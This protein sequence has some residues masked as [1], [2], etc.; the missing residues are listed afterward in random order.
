MFE[1][2]GSRVG[3]LPLG[4]AGSPVPTYDDTGGRL[5]RGF[6][7]DG[8]PESDIPDPDN[9]RG[10]AEFPG[11]PEPGG[12][13]WRTLS[14]RVVDRTSSTAAGIRLKILLPDSEVATPNHQPAA[15]RD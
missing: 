12:T 13:S 1:P 14:V 11:D 10:F 8:Q 3:A 2:A 9:Q 4:R 5:R 6:C 15:C 7:V